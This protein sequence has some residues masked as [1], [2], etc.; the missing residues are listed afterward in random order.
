LEFLDAEEA[1]GKDVVVVG[2]GKSACDCA[3]ALSKVAGST[4]LVSRK[5]IWKLPKVIAGLCYKFLFLGRVGENLFEKIRPGPGRLHTSR[6]DVI[7]RN[8]RVD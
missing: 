5:L 6:Y 8:C 1:R 7:S 4:T 3:V 2:Y